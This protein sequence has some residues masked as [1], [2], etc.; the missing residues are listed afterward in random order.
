MPISI[1][2]SH[3]AGSRFGLSRG[4]SGWVRFRRD[5]REASY[6][7]DGDL[8]IQIRPIQNV[9]MELRHMLELDG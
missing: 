6:A 2:L 8:N 7:F 3:Y 4:S 5:E 9:R 1:C